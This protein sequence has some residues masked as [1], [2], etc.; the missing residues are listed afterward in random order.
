MHEIISYALYDKKAEMYDTPLYFLKDVQAERW[1]Y[2]MAQ[3]KQG[4][5]QHFKDDLELHKICKFNVNNGKIYENKIEVIIQ[6]KQI[7]LEE[8]EK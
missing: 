4:R 5:F 3:E 8:K 2:S 7:Q 6:G 1:F